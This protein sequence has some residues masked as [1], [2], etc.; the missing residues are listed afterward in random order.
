M[1]KSIIQIV[2]GA[3]KPTAMDFI[4]GTK[5][6]FGPSTLEEQE[7]LTKYS[8]KAIK[9][10]SESIREAEVFIKRGKVKI[11]PAKEAENI[12]NICFDRR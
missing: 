12:L 8:V 11:K 2:P 7:I 1:K 4:K 3:V 5:M 9:A 6:A 10:A